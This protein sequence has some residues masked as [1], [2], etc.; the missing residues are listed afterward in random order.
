MVGEPARQFPRRDPEVRSG[1]S[2]PIRRCHGFV[3]FAVRVIE[4][5]RA[6]VRFLRITAA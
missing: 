4:P 6:R 3:E 2:S 5:S 1:D